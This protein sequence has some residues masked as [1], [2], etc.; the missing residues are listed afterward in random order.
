MSNSSSERTS[1]TST[2][3]NE[4]GQ[5]LGL[6]AGDYVQEIGYDDDVDLD[7]CQA[8]ENIIGE[9]IADGD[10]DDVFDVILMWWRSDDDDLIDGLVDA[11]ATL[12]EGGVVWLL[13]P[14]ASR[15]G[16]ISPAD[17]SEAAPTAGMHV[18]STVSA[19]DHWAGFRLVGKKNHS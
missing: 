1:S 15:P 19:A 9:K 7:L 16:H 8:I 2:L 5:N 3:P 18:T 11:Q 13:S 12:K 4:L 10:V 17:I 14:K 6:A